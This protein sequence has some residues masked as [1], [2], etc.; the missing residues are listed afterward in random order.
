MAQTPVESQSLY[1]GVAPVE[2]ASKARL[3]YDYLRVSPVGL[4]RGEADLPGGRSR[5]GA[6][7]AGLLAGEGDQRGGKLVLRAERDLFTVAGNV[8]DGVEPGAGIAAGGVPACSTMLFTSITRSKFT[9][10]LAEAAPRQT[11]TIIVF[12]MP[13]PL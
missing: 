11:R 3:G 4:E 6:V 9:A 10:A 12:F 1:A 13:V 8:G 2:N 7:L 5:I